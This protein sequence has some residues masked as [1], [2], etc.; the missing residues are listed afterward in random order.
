V[1]RG[2]SS[3]VREGPANRHL[4]WGGIIVSYAQ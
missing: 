2:H 1:L 3:E 4:I